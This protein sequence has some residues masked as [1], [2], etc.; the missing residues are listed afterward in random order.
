MVIDTIQD[1]RLEV[2]KPGDTS[3]SA[4][5]HGPEDLRTV[6]I[7]SQIQDVRDRATITYDNEGGRHTGTITTGD[8]LDFYVTYSGPADAAMSGYDASQYDR[9]S[10]DASTQTIHRWTGLSGVPNY[11]KPEGG[12][13]ATVEATDFVFAVMAFRR[14]QRSYINT[15]I[16]TILREI[17]ADKC[18]ELSTGE[19]LTVNQSTDVVY[20]GKSVMD[21]AVELAGR[22]DATMWTRGNRLVFE[23][24]DTVASEWTATATDFGTWSSGGDDDHLLNHLRTEGGTDSKVGDE[25]TVQDGYT[26]VT[27]SSRIQHQIQLPV[28]RIEQVEVWTR[29]ADTGDNVIVRVQEDRGGAPADP[30]DT[31]LDRAS[32]TLAAPFLANDDYTT[33]LL[34]QVDLPAENPWILIESGGADGQDIGIQ[35][36]TGNPTQKT[37]YWYPLITERQSQSSINEYRRREQRDV[38][39]SLSTFTAVRDYGDARI[40]HN[41]EP[42]RTFSGPAASWRAHH[43]EPADVVTLDFPEEAAVGDYIV[44]QRTDNYGQPAGNML[45]T[46]LELQEVETF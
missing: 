44:T 29:P 27:D 2:T 46:D 15:G 20:S 43:L 34:G 23:Q 36:S 3:P 21:A 24:L 12:R 22:A 10:Y 25:Q 38:R 28:S 8:R 4:T 32:R 39:E 5:L 35:S 45:K 17:V 14:L 16:S 7:S 1:A 19:I 31:T 26:R 6:S 30:S 18:P 9:S 41:D 13:Y 33:F 40:A 42:R 37:W 11:H